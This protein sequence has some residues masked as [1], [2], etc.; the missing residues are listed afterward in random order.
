V[1]KTFM[2][3]CQRDFQAGDRIPLL[4][5]EMFQKIELYNIIGEKDSLK[6]KEKLKG[7]P[8]NAHEV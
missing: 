7:F 4:P 3:V 5:N 8:L 2:H 1:I 6:L